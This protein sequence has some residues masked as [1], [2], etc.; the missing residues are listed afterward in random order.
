MYTNEFF[1]TGLFFIFQAKIGEELC[2][3]PECVK[4]ASTILSDV[5]LS[6]DPCEDFYKVKKADLL[7]IDLDVHKMVTRPHGMVLVELVT[8][9]LSH[10]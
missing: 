6:V 3:S 2:L 4:V 10:Y 5:D 7:V 9:H 1:K 8:C